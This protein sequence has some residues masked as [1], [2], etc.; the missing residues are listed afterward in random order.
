MDR[1]TNTYDILYKIYQK[2]RRN[3]PENRTDSAQMCLMWSTNDPPDE[4]EGTE[5]FN[6]LEEAFA[7][8]IAEEDALELYDMT[9]EEATI[10]ITRLQSS[11]RS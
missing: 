3:Y 4:I 10:R 8:N 11:T 5:P 6:D 9:L 7:I 2:H 1:N